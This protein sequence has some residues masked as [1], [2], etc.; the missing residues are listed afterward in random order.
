ML[1]TSLM[2]IAIMLPLFGSCP[3]HHEPESLNITIVLKFSDTRHHL[4]SA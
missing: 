1:F 2:T 3:A 4:A